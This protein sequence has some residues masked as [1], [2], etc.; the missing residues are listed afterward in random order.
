H[1]P[2]AAA[3][4][5]HRRLR[6]PRAAGTGPPRRGRA[7]GT[8]RLP[9]VAAIARGRHVRGRL[10]RACRARG[11]WR[12]PRAPIPEPALRPLVHAPHPCCRCPH[13]LRFRDVLAGK[14]ASRATPWTLKDNPGTGVLPSRRAAIPP[15]GDHLEAGRAQVKRVFRVDSALRESVGEFGGAFW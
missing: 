4:A 9:P 5:A 1:G 15:D 10:T 14:P 12:P 3:C 13:R 7:V 6:R 11:A 2:L 8:W